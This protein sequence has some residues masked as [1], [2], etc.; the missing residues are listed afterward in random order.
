MKKLLTIV[1]LNICLHGVCEQ[2][3]DDFAMAIMVIHEKVPTIPKPFQGDYRISLCYDSRSAGTSRIR[4]LLLH[5]LVGN[6]VIKNYNEQNCWVARFI[7]TGTIKVFDSPQNS[8][9]VFLEHDY[10]K[11]NDTALA[12]ISMVTNYLLA[13]KYIEAMKIDFQIICVSEYNPIPETKL[14]GAEYIYLQPKK[15]ELADKNTATSSFD[16]K[17]TPWFIFAEHKTDSDKYIILRIDSR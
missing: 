9:Y 6:D 8:F 15:R 10:L 7:K 13:R 11:K 5:Y 4:K 1:I 17:E 3:F 14:F 12:N 16:A 2:H